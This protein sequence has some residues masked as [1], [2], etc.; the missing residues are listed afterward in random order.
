MTEVF[1]SINSTYEIDHDNRKVRRIAGV[2]PPTDKF[3]VD[4]IWH[5]F[6]EVDTT[7]WGGRVFYW[8]DGTCTVTSAPAT[9]G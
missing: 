8:P 2:N 7:H 6:G 1:Q 3:Q 9:T 4:G 5:T